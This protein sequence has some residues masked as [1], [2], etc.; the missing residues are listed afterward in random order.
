[1]DRREIL[2]E[3]LRQ[4]TGQRDDDYGKPEYSFQKIAN[5]W[6]AYFDY[7]IA[8]TPKDVAVM[9]A[10]LKIARIYTGVKTDS[11]VDLAGYAA[12]AGELDSAR[13]AEGEQK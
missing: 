5:L 9:M 11:Y 10:L 4:V 1:M 7:R 3:A 8:F 6:N 2:E 13:K 12:C